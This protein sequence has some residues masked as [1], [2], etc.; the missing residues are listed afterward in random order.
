MPHAQGIGLVKAF[1]SKKKKRKKERKARKEFNLYF[2]Q[3]IA[4]PK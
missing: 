2:P 1:L 3:V 4:V